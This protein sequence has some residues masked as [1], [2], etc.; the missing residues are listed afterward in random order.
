V[1]ETG[2]KES[3]FKPFAGPGTAQYHLQQPDHYHLKIRNYQ[4][5]IL[6]SSK[7]LDR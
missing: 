5:S 3:E 2:R 4:L 7:K 6:D 1:A